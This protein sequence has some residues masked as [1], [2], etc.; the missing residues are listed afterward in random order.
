MPPQMAAIANACDQIDWPPHYEL[1]WRRGRGV[2]AL[3]DGQRQRQADGDGGA[4]AEGALDLDGPAQGVDGKLPVQTRIDAMAAQYVEA[5]RSV[6]P[7]GPYRLGGFS[8]GGVIAFEM[9]QQLT[10]AGQRIALLG[11][12]NGS[13]NAVPW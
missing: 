7:D 9:A 5:V 8:G 1:G 11:S 4:L 3:D 2:Q 12:M 13:E 10:R 6:E